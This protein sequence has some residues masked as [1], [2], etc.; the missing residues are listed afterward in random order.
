MAQEVNMQEVKKSLVIS[1]ITQDRQGIVKELSEVVHD[2][3]CNI[4][5]SRMMVMQGV[6]AIL[7]MVSGNTNKINKLKAQEMQLS[8]ALGS[9]VQMQITKENNTLNHGKPYYI[10]VVALD[11]QGIVKELSDFVSSHSINIETLN[12]ETYSAP[13]TGSTM[14]RLEMSVNI[15]SNI[16]IAKFKNDLIDHCDE[17]NL[18]VIVEPIVA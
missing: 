17:K 12:T 5:D 8:D 13:Y 3:D 16:Q 1:L 6:F 11:H 14:F 10:E 7:M 15:P 4:D 2:Y 18:D 9:L